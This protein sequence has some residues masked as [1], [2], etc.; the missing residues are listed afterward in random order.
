MRTVPAR[1]RYGPKRT[2]HPSEQA[3]A[4]HCRTTP[5][6]PAQTMVHLHRPPSGYLTISAPQCR[7]M[8]LPPLQ[9][10]MS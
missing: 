7:P 3:T 10:N 2:S 6:T 5:A 9:T 8:S 4:D 1:T